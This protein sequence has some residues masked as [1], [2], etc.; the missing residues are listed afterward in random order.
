MLCITVVV[1]VVVVVVFGWVVA[2]W[3]AVL[4]FAAACA[5]VA[6]TPPASGHAASVSA[7]MTARPKRE[8]R[9]DVAPVI[10]C[11]LVPPRCASRHSCAEYTNLAQNKKARSKEIRAVGLRRREPLTQ[12]SRAGAGCGGRVRCGIGGTYSAT[13]ARVVGLERCRPSSS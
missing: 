6:P 7:S 13:C 8:R 4:V 10:A 1:V 12:G 3:A 5:A 2:A 11:R 9:E